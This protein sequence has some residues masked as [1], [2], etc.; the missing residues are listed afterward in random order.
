MYTN[1]NH[2]SDYKVRLLAIRISAIHAFHE[3]KLTLMR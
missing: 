1:Y 3:T 2:I